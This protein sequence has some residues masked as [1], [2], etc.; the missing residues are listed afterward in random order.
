[1]SVAMARE[2]IAH[3]D[4]AR[5][6][7]TEATVDPPNGDDVVTELHDGGRDLEDAPAGPVGP[8]GGTDLPR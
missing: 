1:M 7:P 4:D 5:R 2:C 8:V 3:A 6:P